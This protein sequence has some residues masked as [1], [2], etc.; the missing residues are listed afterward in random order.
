MST[1]RVPRPRALGG[2]DL[3]QHGVIEASAGT[4]KTFTIEHLVVELLLSTEARLPEILVVTFTEKATAELVA[5][6]RA[7]ILRLHLAAQSD[8]MADINDDGDDGDDASW[9]LDDDARRR[10]RQAL[11]DLDRA[12]ISTIHGFCNRVLAESAFSAHRLLEEKPA[13][14]LAIGKEAFEEMVRTEL[15]VDAVDRRWLDAWLSKKSLESLADLLAKARAM[16][17]SPP[18]FD[19]V[20]LAAVL[21]ELA[22]LGEVVA[23]ARVDQ[24]KAVDNGLAC[25]ADAIVAYGLERD[26]PAAVAALDAS[27]VDQL[28]GQYHERLDA[29]SLKRVLESLSSVLPTLETA[30]AARLLR[31][32]SERLQAL[33]R[34]R[35][36]Y[37]FDDM[38]TWTL[39]ALTGPGGGDLTAALRARYR[40]AL[41]DEFQDT[42]EVQ[43]R[44]FERIFFQ[45]TAPARPLFLVG[46][47]K[48]SIYG[49]RG[50][51][52]ETYLAACRAIRDRGGSSVTLDENFRSTP[53]LLGAVHVLLD[54]TVEQPLFPTAGGVTYARPVRAGRPNAK[55]TD[56]VGREVAPLVVLSV[57]NPKRTKKKGGPKAP[58]APEVRAIVGKAMAAEAHRLLY[59][60]EPLLL[61]GRPIGAGDVFFLSRSKSEADEMAGY[62]AA[63]GVPY[64]FYKQEGLLGGDE[65]WEIL[66]LLRV[67]ERPEARARQMGAAATAFFGGDLGRLRPG[68]DPPGPPAADLAHW[69]SLADEGRWAALFSALVRDTGLGL[70]AGFVGEARRLSR[71]RQIFDL[72]LEETTQARMSL[73]ELCQRLAAWHMGEA[74]PARTDA[75]VVRAELDADEAQSAV[76]IMTVHKSKGLEAAVVFL[77]GGF[78]ASSRP[79]SVQTYHRNGRRQAVFGRARHQHDRQDVE[80][81]D[82]AENAR[83]WYVALTRARA[84]LYLP[85]FEGQRKPPYQTINDQ[86]ER[87][88]SR[89]RLLF[90]GTQELEL[91]ACGDNPVADMEANAEA[92]RRPTATATVAGWRPAE[93]LLRVEKRAMPSVPAGFE[94]TSYTKLKE[95]EGD[96]RAVLVR[97]PPHPLGSDELPAG[98]AS[99]IFLH[100]LLERLPLGP[101]AEAATAEAYFARPEVRAIVDGAVRRHDVA[102]AH[103]GHAERMVYAAYTTPILRMPRGL[104]SAERAVREMEFLY[105]QPGGDLVRGFVDYL[106]ETGGRVY[107]ADWKSDL[108][109]DYAGPFLSDVVWEHYGLQIKV[110]SV[111]LVRLLG[112][113]DEAGYERRFGGPCYVFLR[114]L[115]VAGAGVYCQRPSWSM[116]TDWAT[117][118]GR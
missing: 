48:Q 45:S 26:L 2:L 107:F 104:G 92:E 61:D 111:A 70:R 1:V 88:V 35:G 80:L 4:G 17:V 21:D 38:L 103:R 14:Q 27:S 89:T 101:L 78:G 42:D 114:G 71:Y 98:A 63:A 94:I 64:A 117:E 54:Q 106:F 74:R 91:R 9:L 7:T 73:G 84:R 118:L 49:F 5:R 62:L 95:G 36:L 41:V 32:F 105:P 99:G 47:P 40:F 65:A 31:R 108:L 10:L 115:S 44:I 77:F 116:V 6:V 100:E 90:A 79:R 68:E 67:I 18:S 110:Y 20:A 34:A 30:M 12:Q 57:G 8:G 52:V 46:D 56:H 51:D 93:D 55:L 43:W 76:Q 112:I 16:R 87:A 29:P 25:V 3:R 83:I 69:R 15:A 28:W 75:D 58:G 37:D 97:P 22:P 59:S 11:D 33:E 24:I 19:E 81:E 53:A 85:W 39:E 86:L 102:A 60:G 113:E 66:Q 13:D 96:D 72:L 50:A 109:P 82:T 23:R